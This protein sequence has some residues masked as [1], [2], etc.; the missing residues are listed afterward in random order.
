MGKYL[1]A[2]ASYTD[3]HG[4]GKSATSAASSQVAVGNINPSFSSMTAT[5]SVPENSGANVNVG[6]PVSATGG[7]SDPL[8]YSS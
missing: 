1:K 7:D 6:A 5:R 8:V 2:T 4:S 3:P